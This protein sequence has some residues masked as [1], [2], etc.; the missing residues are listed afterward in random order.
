MRAAFST[1]R[2]TSSSAHLLD[3]QR[4]G[5][6]LEDGHVR[7]E[8]VA[9]EHH[10]DAALDRR[11]VVDPLAVDDDV[12]RGGVRRARRSCAAASTCRSRT[13][14]RRRRTRPRAR[15]A[16]RSSPRRMCAEALDDVAQGKLTHG[17]PP[18]RLSGDPRGA[19]AAGTAVARLTCTARLRRR[20]CRARPAARPR[21]SRP[22]APWRSWRSGSPCS[23]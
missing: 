3:P 4:E 20:P 21:R 7:V 10:G 18:S 14:R 2:R 19:A 16:R 9:L 22:T 5:D 17:A 12:A 13:G 11:Q 8:R 23:R 15:R 1:L 6:V